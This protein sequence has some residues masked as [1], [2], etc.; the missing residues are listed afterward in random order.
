MK[1]SIEQRLEHYF[2]RLW[3]IC[4]SL[5]GDGVRQSI[6][7]LKEIIPLTVHEVPTGTVVHD[8]TIPQE[9]NIKDAWIETPN[10]DKV[11]CFKENN[12]HLLGYSTPIDQRMAWHELEPHL[13][14][15]PEQ[16]DAVPYR[17][18]YY[19]PQWGFCLSKHQYD[20]LPK[21]GTYHVVIDSS[22][23]E[24]SLTYGD[25]VLAGEQQEEIFFSSYICHPSLANNELSGP[26]VQAFLYEYVSQLK[27]RRYSY[28]FLL[29]PETI[30]SIAYLSEHG[31]HLRDTMKAGY[32][33]TC[34]G[35]PQSIRYKRSRDG[36]AYNDRVA[37]RV[38]ENNKFGIDYKFVDFF[39][40]GSD[41]R[42]Y[43]SPG[44]NLP[45]GSIVRGMYGEYPEYHTSLDDK[46]LLSFN[47][48]NQVL[49]LY[50]S[51]VDTIEADVFY[52]R[53]DPFCEPQLG[54]RGIYPQTGGDNISQ[55]THALLWILNLS[56]ANTCLEDIVR[57]SGLS[58]NLLQQAS[59]TLLHNGLINQV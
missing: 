3:P 22:L 5:T 25:I 8:W 32:I 6:D 34:V 33:L 50:K 1:Q 10:G 14:F 48:L 47:A 57:R 19:K 17:T 54:K 30:G 40:F 4:R 2:D 38:L 59:Q 37:A 24:G 35:L 43:C 16:P 41:E 29:A 46:S 23:E 56:D 39:P 26:L 7:I 53:T 11:A 13:H 49:E 31:P 36:D 42:Q 20:A 21:N 58:I 55:Q 45:I 44:Y 27:T 18:S 15:L 12:L 52:R 9:W 51:I 28:R